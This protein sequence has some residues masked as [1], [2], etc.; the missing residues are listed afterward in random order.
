MDGSYDTNGRNGGNSMEVVEIKTLESY[1]DMN[2][3]CADFI[4]ALWD[5]DVVDSEEVRKLCGLP[6]YE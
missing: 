5:R 1:F 4:L 3:E 2:K 6:D